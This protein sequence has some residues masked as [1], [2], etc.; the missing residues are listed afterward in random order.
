MHMCIKTYISMHINIHKYRIHVS[1]C[2]CMYMYMYMYMYMDTHTSMHTFAFFANI[3]LHA[4]IH[5]RV[6]MH[7]TCKHT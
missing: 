7:N 3:R 5:R 4:E 2:V 1:M 6:Y